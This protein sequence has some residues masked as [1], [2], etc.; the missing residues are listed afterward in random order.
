MVM[1]LK[2]ILII[3]FYL[4]SSTI[5]GCGNKN[6]SENNDPKEL[7]FKVD[8]SLLGEKFIDN[9]LEFSFSPP[10]SCLQM[11]EGIVQ[12]VKDRF[13]Q[14]Y[15]VPNSFVIEPHMF[16]LNENDQFACLISI[17]PTLTNADNSIVKY[18]QAIC[19]QYIDSQVS[20]ADFL[21][22]G[23][24]IYQS[25][26][27][28]KDIVQ[29]KLVVTQSVNKSFQIDYVIPKSI[30]QDNLKAIESS[31]GSLTKLNVS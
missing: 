5:Q 19:T 8:N 2:I 25:L 21:H 26:I 22:N 28:S 18:Q 6:H 29:F 15:T 16:F 11:S 14:E 13:K 31:I 3:S 30:Y 12:K 4:I 1:T 24:R 10:N 20:Q 17:L 7:T 9:Y 23:F 27:I